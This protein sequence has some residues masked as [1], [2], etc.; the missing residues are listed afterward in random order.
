MPKFVCFEYP[1]G[2]SGFEIEY[3]VSASSEPGFSGRNFLF[4][5]LSQA[6]CVDPF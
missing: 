2:L 1:P 4:A 6:A 3:S 5:G